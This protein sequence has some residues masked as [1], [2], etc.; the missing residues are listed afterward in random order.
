MLRPLGRWSHVATALFRASQWKLRD[1]FLLLDSRYNFALENGAK[2]VKS[3]RPTITFRCMPKAGKSERYSY[4]GVAGPWGFA[5]LQGATK[6]SGRQNV[7]SAPLEP[8][9]HVMNLR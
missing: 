9:Q 4:N 5:N 2:P 1:W 3:R 7:F 6:L 8:H